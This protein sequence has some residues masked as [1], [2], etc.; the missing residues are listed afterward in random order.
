MEWLTNPFWIDWIMLIKLFLE[1]EVFGVPTNISCDLICLAYLDIY[2]IFKSL[3]WYIHNYK[4]LFDIY[5]IISFWKDIYAFSKK[6]DSHSKVSTWTLA[7]TTYIHL[8]LNLIFMLN[9]MNIHYYMCLWQVS[10]KPLFNVLL[11]TCLWLPSS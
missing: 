1:L 8:Y 3:K 6:N 9:F 2:I 11:P 7:N 10:G 5:A 4:F